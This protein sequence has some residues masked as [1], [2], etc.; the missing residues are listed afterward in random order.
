M[1]TSRNLTRRP[2]AVG[3]SVGQLSL[4]ELH[5]EVLRRVRVLQEKKFDLLK[6]LER[7]ETEL[8]A[9]GDLSASAG[10]PGGMSSGIRSSGAAR[11]RRLNKV[12]LRDLLVRLLHNNP[13]STR[14]AS[15]A[16]L[17]AGYVTSSRNFVNS[18][19]VAMNGDARFCRD[20]DGKWCLAKG[21]EVPDDVDDDED[22]LDDDEDDD[23]D[24]D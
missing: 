15:E 22:D 3:L 17:A 13:L 21:V 24:D 11:S 16:A 5:Q 14:E 18:V 6:E 12:S 20:A 8:G 1:N 9:I 4:A 23:S 7:I 2:Q 10:V 19:G